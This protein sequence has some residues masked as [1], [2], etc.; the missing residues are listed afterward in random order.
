MAQFHL[1]NSDLGVAPAP[2]RP[3]LNY[4]RTSTA[5]YRVSCYT[6][7]QLYTQSATNLQCQLSLHLFPIYAVHRL[8]IKK[9]CLGVILSSDSLLLSYFQGNTLILSILPSQ[10]ISVPFGRDYICSSIN[11]EMKVLFYHLFKVIYQFN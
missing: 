4:A 6:A 9:C 8:P 5:L 10:I 2:Y 3:Q 7:G 1:M 11:N